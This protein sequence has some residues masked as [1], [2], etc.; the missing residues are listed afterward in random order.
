MKYL[1]LYIS[2]FCFLGFTDLNNFKDVSQDSNEVQVNFDWLLGNWKR[3]NDQEGLQTF[4]H[5][6]KV[7]DTVLKG[8]G[9]ILKESDTVWQESIR[10]IK[11]KDDWN[12]EVS[13][14]D[15]DEPTIF[16]VTKIEME[17]FTCENKAN[18]FPK[19]IRYAKVE[20]GLNAVISGEGKVVLFQF[21][22]LP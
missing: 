5:W 1:L 13:D 4:E 14:Q 21:T 10:L 9:Y 7:N 8:L 16:K 2:L 12:F 22:R 20:K 17:S 19:K 3:T 18:E 11:S 15:A 6:E